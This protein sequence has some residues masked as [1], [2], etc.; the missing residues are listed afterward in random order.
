MIRDPNNVLYLGYYFSGAASLINTA[1]V[2][3]DCW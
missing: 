2:S 3:K 1:L